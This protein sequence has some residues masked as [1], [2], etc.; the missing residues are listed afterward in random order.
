MLSVR[1]SRERR[2]C[3]SVMQRAFAEHSF[4]VPIH[5]SANTSP[6]QEVGQVSESA[7]FHFPHSFKTEEPCIVPLEALMSI[8]CT[9]LSVSFPFRALRE[10]S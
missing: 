9:R 1:E 5:T 3:P 7:S 6:D 2:L 8:V 10:F 4:D